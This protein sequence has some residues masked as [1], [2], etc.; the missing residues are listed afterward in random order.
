VEHGV[1][2]FFSNGHARASYSE[3]FTD[4]ADLDKLDWEAIYSTQ[5]NND[6]EHPGRK[7]RKQS[8]LMAKDWV[9]KECLLKIGVYNERAS[10]RVRL[11]L[12]HAGMEHLE[13]HLS[14]KKLY[15]DHL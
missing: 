12:Q 10:D 5:W 2:F 7:D 15:Y 11:Y 4:V 6:S 1:S 14:P 8:E 3:K 13:I 9:P